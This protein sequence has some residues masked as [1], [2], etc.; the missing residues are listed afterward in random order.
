MDD[1][2]SI[3]A[4]DRFIQAT[5]DSGYKSTVSAVSELIDNSLQAGAR[6]VQVWVDR[7]PAPEPDAS[8]LEGRCLFEVGILDDGAGMDKE[9]LELA[10][11]FGGSSRFG[12]R[13]GMGRYGMGLPNASL[14]QARRVEVYTWQGGGAPLMCYLDVDEIAEGTLKRVRRAK[15]AKLPALYAERVDPSQG[16]L[17]LWR[18]CDRLDNRRQT[19]ITQKLHKNLGRVFR[20]YLWEG[21]EVT[22][23]C[24]S[25]R[26]VDPLF[27]DEHASNLAHMSLREGMAHTAALYEELKV[28]LRCPETGNKGKVKVR[29]SAL[30]VA[31]WH[32][33]PN[34]EKRGRGITRAAGVSVVRA[35]REVDYGWHF[36]GGKRKE[37]YDDWWRCEVQFGPELDELFGI[38]HTKQQIK[39]KA[40]LQ[41]SFVPLLEERARALNQLARSA[42][43]AVKEAAR[44][45]PAEEGRPVQELERARPAVPSQGATSC[46]VFDPEHPFVSAVEAAD[47]ARL[48]VL[49]V[50]AA[51]AEAA[52]AA[53]GEAEADALAR[54]LERWGAALAQAVAAGARR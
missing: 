16:T 23:N 43:T 17:A 49:Q 37:P 41:E 24:G 31:A 50:L 48:S 36:M 53:E 46:G 32:D 3:V 10:M 19:T 9:T 11:Q 26:P 5:R 27:L 52:Q 25:V 6:R 12:D 4:V 28:K 44:E 47:D 45:A 29:F 22:V 2:R 7:L 8:E 15:R 40:A 34:P 42:F 51:A 30:P 38:T 54:F 33:M 21:V 35:G 1:G 39:P 20:H 18:R 14:S 13:G